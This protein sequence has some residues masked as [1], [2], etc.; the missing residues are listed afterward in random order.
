M[1]RRATTAGTLLAA[2]ALLAATAAGAAAGAEPGPPRLATE[3][4]TARPTVGDLVTVELRLELPAGTA[5]DGEPR[6]PAWRD[7]WGGAEVV[8]A[9][10]VAMAEAAG[11]GR[12]WVQAVVLQVFRPGRMPLPPREVAVPL[13]TGTV[14]LSTPAALAVEVASVLPPPAGDAAAIPPA[15]P[16]AP[17][18]ALPWGAAFWWTAV[19]GAA[20]C[21]AAV[22]LLRRRLREESPAAPARPPAPPFE[23]LLAALA[24]ARGAASP[25][26]GHTTLS[27]ALRRYLGRRLHFPALESTT[28]EVQRHLLSRHLPAALP[29]QSVELLRAC[30]LVKFARRPA[31]AGAVERWAAEAE[32]VAGGLETHL[33]PA[34]PAEAAA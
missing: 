30:D 15:A 4:V 18:V 23:E 21:L 20:L 10:R 7:A 33:R 6:F 12:S 13:A 28:T 11:G 2:A 31:T 14:R 3:V 16:A 25:A 19:V 27:E 32:A 9:G 8:E 1:S 24:A 17:P 26:E 5:L 29:R 22:L 34:E